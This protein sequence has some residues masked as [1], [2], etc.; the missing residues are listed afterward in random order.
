M[1]FSVTGNSIRAQGY[2]HRVLHRRKWTSFKGRL[3]AKGYFQ[4]YGVDI[5][6]TFSPVM[7]FS[8]IRTILAFAVQYRMLIHQMDVTIAFLNRVLTEEIYMEQPEGYVILGK[9]NLV[10]RLKK[11]LYGLKQ[12]PCCWN[13]KFRDALESLN[14]RQGQA[15]PCIFVKGSL[16]R[17]NL[18][19]IAVY[20][21][22]LI[23]IS[24]TQDGNETN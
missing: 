4:K 9:E 19:T 14:F 22:D 6:E 23:I 3:V 11:F 16:E 12:S 2:L 18:T 8:S 13:Q 1:L 17:N 21:D 15:E 24:T 7:R 5:D 10:C 20:V